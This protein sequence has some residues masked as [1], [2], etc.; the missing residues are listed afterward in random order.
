MKLLGD[1]S[2]PKVSEENDQVK[3]NKNQSQE[4]SGNK[5]LKKKRIFD[6]GRENK[7]Q[8]I[9]RKVEHKRKHMKK[10]DHSSNK[11]KQVCQFYV[12]GACHKGNECTFS[13]DVQQIKRITE[14][15]KYVLTGSCNKGEECLYSHDFKSFPC[16]FFHAIGYCENGENCR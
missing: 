10:L 5:F 2:K 11:K 4:D 7:A 12:N 16:K 15:C 3:K 13:H 14:L 9:N 1:K 6:Q 8:E